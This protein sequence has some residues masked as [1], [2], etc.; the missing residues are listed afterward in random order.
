MEGFER[1]TK[2]QQRTKVFLERLIG[3]DDFEADVKHWRKRQSSVYAILSGVEDLRK[4]YKLPQNAILFVA[5][6]IT[7]GK[8]D[9]SLISPPAYIIGEDGYHS[10]SSSVIERTAILQ[11]EE[12]MSTTASSL[13]YWS[14]PPQPKA[15]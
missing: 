13:R 9:F 4:K 5:N 2:S 1:L 12:Y 6:Y 8:A 14:R 7:N 10:I 3:S 11:T 15:S